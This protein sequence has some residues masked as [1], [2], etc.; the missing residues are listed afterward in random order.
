MCLRTTANRQLFNIAQYQTSMLK[1]YTLLF[2]LVLASEIFAQK[3]NES[4]TQKLYE[5]NALLLTT[6]GPMEN[7]ALLRKEPFGKDPFVQRLKT[8][9]E[10]Y[11]LYKKGR[12]RLL[13][14]TIEATA[15]GAMAVQTPI[16]LRYAENK[17]QR[18][19]SWGFLGIGAGLFY[20]GTRTFDRGAKNISNATWMYNRAAILKEV[21][22]STTRHKVEHWYDTKT[23]Y[24]VPRGYI[25]D[26]KFIK[27]DYTDTKLAK[28]M[29]GNSIALDNLK[30][31]NRLLRRGQTIQWSALAVGT[32]G[33]L[34]T[35]TVDTRIQR[36][37]S[38]IIGGIGFGLNLV[39]AAPMLVKATNHYNQ[40]VW[41]YNRDAR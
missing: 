10:A 20:L 9:P 19:V 17:V 22:D 24:L 7:G 18:G 40:A 3:S 6:S 33:L 11:H 25:Q 1:F 23:I 38:L 37:H 34:Q 21:T 30:K 5:R 28:L 8:V 32:F 39:V 26:G 4:Y 14:G 2:G 13:F 31:G 27:R 16:L 35:L 12:N 29:R 36:R 41:F 15:S